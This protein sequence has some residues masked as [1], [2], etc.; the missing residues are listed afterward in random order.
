MGH[1]LVHAVEVIE[2]GERQEQRKRYCIPILAAFGC[3]DVFSE[4]DSVFFFHIRY[5]LFLLFI[6][7][8]KYK[9]ALLFVAVT[10]FAN[11]GAEHHH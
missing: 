9:F 8:L 5:Y 1:E 6:I 10:I 11:D 3:F 7:L 2:D 4:V